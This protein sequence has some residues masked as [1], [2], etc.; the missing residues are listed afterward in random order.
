MKA[1]LSTSIVL[2][3]ALIG[4]GLFTLSAPRALEVANVE[5][6]PVDIVPIEELTQ[7]QEGDKKS[8]LNEK[9]APLPTEKPEPVANAQ[10]VGEAEVDVEA[11]PTPQTKPVPVETAAAPPPSPEPVDLPKLEAVEPEMAEPASVPATEAA[12]VPEPK[13]A[14]EP[15][16]VKEA[17]TPPPE[18]PAKPE[19]A[20]AAEPAPPAEPEPA[21]DAEQVASI[22]PEKPKTEELILPASAPAPETR[23]KP[24]AQ[25]A[26]APERKE[27]EKPVKE[28]A[29]KPKSAEKEF[30]ADEVAALLNKAAPSGGG[31]KRS[32]E[33]ASLGGKKTTGGAKLSQGEM[34]ALSNQLG[35]CWS[36]PAGAEGL[37]GMRVSIRF[38]VD[39]SGKVDGRPAVET[40]SG[41]RSFDESAIRAVQKCDR[42]GLLLPMD[43]ADTW[44]EIVVNF[45]PSAM[46]F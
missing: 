20:K 7:I 27:S 33:T 5:S 30:D 45:D 11:P 41:N 23:P 12:P 19:P 26:K 38:N 14:V 25:T 40:T 1:G 2:H 15:E 21:E 24:Q 22:T 4:F 18:P 44:S 46:L 16:P 35:G 13:A 28:A 31:A 34:D 9:A 36:L 6:F 39:A 8:P 10:R 43:K 17:E 32:T 29:Q 42:Q 37:D 3:V